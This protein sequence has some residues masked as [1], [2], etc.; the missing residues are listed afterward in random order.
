M[1]KNI[2]VCWNEDSAQ[3]I[4][5]MAK[6]SYL[7]TKENMVSILGKRSKLRGEIEKIVNGNGEIDS[8]RIC[9]IPNSLK[10]DLYKKVSDDFG[11]ISHGLSQEEKAQKLIEIIDKRELEFNQIIADKLFL[12][13]VV[14][15][16]T[17][18]KELNKVLNSD[19]KIDG[20]IVWC[21]L[22]WNDYDSPD[23]YK[24]ISLVQHFIRYEKKMNTPVVFTSTQNLHTIIKKRPDANIIATPAL[25]H[26]FV[27]FSPNIE[28]L[29]HCFDNMKEITKRQLEYALNR[30]CDLKGLLSHIKHNCSNGSIDSYKTQLLYAVTKLFNNDS[31]KLNEVQAASSDKE[32]IRICE[33]YIHE[34]QNDNTVA[35]IKIV[36]YICDSE[37]KQLRT[38]ILDDNEE[39]ECT[40]RLVRCMNQICDMVTSKNSICSIAKP[41]VARNID[42]FFSLLDEDSSFNNIILD[43]EIWNKSEE[44][45]ALGFDIAEEVRTRMTTP[46]QIN[47]ITNIT[48]SLHSKLID[49]FNNDVVKG[50][51]LKEDI[52]SSDTQTI[53]FIK[54]I[55]QEWN[56]Y[57]NLYK[58]PQ[59]N[60]CKV[61]QRLITTVKRRMPNNVKIKLDFDKITN[62]GKTD[63]R[64]YTL[65]N[66]DE[67]EI[68][69]K[70]ITSELIK[71]FLS[72]FPKEASADDITW[73]KF[74]SVCSIMRRVV[75]DS[76]GLGNEKLIDKIMG[77]KK[78]ASKEPDTDDINNFVS[79]L[80]LRRFFL[81]LKL[82]INNYEITRKFDYKKT[83]DE[84][85]EDVKW[86]YR[87][88]DLACRA[89]SKQFKRPFIDEEYNTSKQSKCLTETLLYSIKIDEKDQLSEEEKAFV[90]SVIKNEDSFNIGKYNVLVFEY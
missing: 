45:E 36:D 88:A 65:T 4:S 75:S 6:K 23:N 54:S 16:C 73:E 86:R 79:R 37:E 77:K 26:K 67:L 90:E 27:Q 83:H 8:E 63:I 10:D 82:F 18:F 30:F 61:Y 24:G 3:S 50:I 28:D 9:Q 31:A 64:L 85:R 89:I 35:N 2:I 43:I 87:D 14:S 17:S 38:L 47:M 80:V 19:T 21:D 53:S 34:L 13:N 22:E 44:L 49:N 20:I 15:V 5:D 41:V 60:C 76:I 69:I 70:D 59:F 62:S 74:D 52:L 71:R 78:A 1:E 46:V 11:K 72:E 40:N 58:A 29:L 39:D 56:N 84:D 66:Y 48:R 32:I 55:N 51:Y 57:F 12:Y 42:D 25:Q 33:K 81:Y 7:A 68:A